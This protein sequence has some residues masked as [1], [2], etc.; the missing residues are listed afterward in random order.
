MLAPI[1]AA[2]I[3]LSVGDVFRWEAPDARLREIEVLSIED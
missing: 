2:L 3:G 1:G